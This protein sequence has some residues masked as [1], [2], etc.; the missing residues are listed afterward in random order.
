F[1]TDAVPGWATIAASVLLLGGLQLIGLG[2]I[3]EYIGRI[4]EEVKQRPLYW[5]SR[6]ISGNTQSNSKKKSAVA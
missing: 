3:G 2:I 5:V 1:T 4:F 6:E